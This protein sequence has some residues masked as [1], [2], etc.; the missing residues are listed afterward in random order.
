MP[1][2]LFS[3]QASSIPGWSINPFPPFSIGFPRHIQ[4]QLP[5]LVYKIPGDSRWQQGNAE[6]TLL[7]LCCFPVTI[8]IFAAL[9]GSLICSVAFVSFDPV[10]F[11]LGF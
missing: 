2:L 11:V 5:G 10:V 4:L 7:A 1:G 6:Q 9:I 3:I 8:Y